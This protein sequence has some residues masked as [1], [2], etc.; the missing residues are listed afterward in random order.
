MKLILE[1]DK[2]EKAAKVDP[3]PPDSPLPRRR[4]LFIQHGETDEPGL[5][6]EVSIAAGCAFEILHPYR[7]DEIP[8]VPHGIDG[9]ALGGGAQGV[10]EQDAY[11]YLREEISLAQAVIAEGK[12]AIG[13]CLGGQLLA[14]A[15]GGTVAPAGYREVGV[16][17]VRFHPASREDPLFF[18][19]PES[20][21]VAH[22]HGD[23]F[24]VPHDAQV[25]ACSDL[26]PNQLFAWKNRVYGFQ[27]HLEMTPDILEEMVEDSM[28]D[29]AAIGVDGRSL[30]EAGHRSLPGTASFARSVFQRWFALV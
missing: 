3:F 7:G 30:A 14:A 25:L 23:A 8:A 12:P 1:V 15:L 29:L 6:E 2:I 27:F 20:V 17:P 26:T 5:L 19:A 18:D 21:L 4:V 9:L 10:Y 13:L 28:A 16:L 24:T 11:P 22:W